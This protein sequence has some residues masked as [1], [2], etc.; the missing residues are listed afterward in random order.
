MG[1][2]RIGHTSLRVMDMAAAV[3][4][5]ENVLGMKK[6]WRTSRATCTSSV[7]TSGTSIR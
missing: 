1:I 3:K 4:H 6:P 5:Y 2:M 7:G